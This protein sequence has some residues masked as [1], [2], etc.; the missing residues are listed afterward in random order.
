M[1]DSPL[2]PTPVAGSRP[3]RGRVARLATGVLLIAY[4]WVMLTVVPVPYIKVEPGS[5]TDVLDLI[6]VEGTSRF[7]ADGELLFL[8]VSLSKRVTPLEAIF[9]WFDHDVQLLREQVYTQNRSRE[10]LTRLN[11]AVMEESKLVAIKVALERL[12]YAVEAVGGGALVT[13]V[14]PD[15]P[16][17][18]EIKAGDVV[19]GVDGK[20]ITLRDQAIEGVRAHEPGDPVSLTVERG[21]EETTLTVKTIE[22]DEGTAQVGI[23]L[24]DTLEFEFPFDV[25]IDTGQVGGPS[26]GLAFTLAV[27]DELTEGELTGGRAVAVTGTIELNGTVEPVG[28]VEQKA[29]AAREAGAALMIVPDGEAEA[30]RPF[31]GRMKVV[32]VKTLDDALEALAGIGG[33]ALA[34]PPPA[35]PS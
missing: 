3:D 23:F 28:G 29:V 25:D 22:G 12:G 2:L 17:A 7:E 1:N 11:L 27:I 15:V 5:A 33:N 34:L 6:S 14:A 16:A 9:A 35:P 8:T 13:G 10:E 21:G 31:A 4:S 19:V 30:A 32:A 24:E 20:R 18:R 26:A